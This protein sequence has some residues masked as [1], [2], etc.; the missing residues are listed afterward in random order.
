MLEATRKKLREAQFFREQLS[1][2]DRRFF[3]PEPE[4]RDFYLSAFL[5][6]ARSVGDYIAAE[7]GDRYRQWFD[8]RRQGLSAEEQELLSFTNRQR[9]H[10]VHVRGA[11]VV[12]KITSVPIVELQREIESYGGT[13]YVFAGGV[14]GAP[15]PLPTAEKSTLGFADRPTETVVELCERYLALLSR[16]VDEYE[17]EVSLQGV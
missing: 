13:F 11:N 16:L 8:A 7:E 17:A 10:S 1:N 6:A 12:P 14:P 3:R 9:T 15:E 4:A 5:S 2:Q